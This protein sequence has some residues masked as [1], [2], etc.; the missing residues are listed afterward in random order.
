[1]KNVQVTLEDNENTL[2]IKVDLTKSLGPSSSGKTMLVATSEGNQPIQR[3]SADSVMLGLN[4]Y[5]RR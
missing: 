1:M 2:V 5:K 3:V 4:V